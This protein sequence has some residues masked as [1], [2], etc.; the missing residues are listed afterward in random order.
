MNKFTSRPIVFYEPVD[1]AER[2]VETMRIN[3]VKFNLNGDLDFFLGFWI[4]PRR[5]GEGYSSVPNSGEG[6]GRKH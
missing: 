6:N 4:L 5:D 2:K 1:T 3:S